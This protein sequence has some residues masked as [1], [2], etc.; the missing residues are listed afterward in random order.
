MIII[1][2]CNG[3]SIKVSDMWYEISF[4]QLIVICNMKRKKENLSM[5]NDGC[6]ETLY[7]YGFTTQ[8]TPC[9][10]FKNDDAITNVFKLC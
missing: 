6:R 9:L 5:L 8:Y 1:I 7:G 4:M 10:A 2:H 3:N